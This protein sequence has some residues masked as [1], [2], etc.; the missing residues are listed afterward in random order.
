MSSSSFIKD[1]VAFWWHAWG[2]IV[3]PLLEFLGLPSLFFAVCVWI[4]RFIES[5]RKTRSYREA[6]SL[7]K[8]FLNDLVTTPAKVFVVL[9]LLGGFVL[10]PVKLSREDQ[11]QLQLLTSSNSKLAQ[12]DGELEN[13][14]EMVSFSLRQYRGIVSLKIKDGSRSILS[15]TMRSSFHPSAA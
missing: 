12:H 15:I 5:Y 14:L 3:A 7:S 13:Q 6:L 9:F 11:A 4:G 1:S 2:A 8:E 10:G